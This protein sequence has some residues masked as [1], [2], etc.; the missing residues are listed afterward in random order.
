V[1]TKTAS[2]ALAAAFAAT[3][4]ISAAQAG[5]NNVNFTA[6]APN[7]IHNTIPNVPDVKVHPQMI[8]ARLKV[9]HCYPTRERNELGVWVRRTHCN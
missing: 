7:A 6:R 3:V 8:D 2:I 4:S 9:L 1:L 5:M